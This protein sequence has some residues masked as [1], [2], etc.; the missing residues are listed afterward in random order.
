MSISE[1]E[2]K[3][4]TDT[5][6]D[7]S[8]PFPEIYDAI[9][10]QVLLLIFKS[11]QLSQNPEYKDWFEKQ[12]VVLNELCAQSNKIVQLLDSKSQRQSPSYWVQ[13]IIEPIQYALLFMRP[14][15][16]GFDSGVE[17]LKT[18]G[19]MKHPNVMKNKYP[20]LADK[21]LSEFIQDDFFSI[22][23]NNRPDNEAI[24]A[25]VRKGYSH[26]DLSIAYS[27]GDELIKK[28]SEY[29][30]I[31]VLEVLTETI[32]SFIK[33]YRHQNINLPSWLSLFDK[34]PQ[35][36][37]SGN[38]RDSYEFKKIIKLLNAGGRESFINEVISICGKNE[39]ERIYHRYA[40][41]YAKEIAQWISG[42]FIYLKY[43]NNIDYR[44][45]FTTISPELTHS[46][47][48]CEY[49]DSIAWDT[50]YCQ[51]S[52]SKDNLLDLIQNNALY[53]AT[54]ILADRLWHIY[55]ESATK[56]SNN[57]D[58]HLPVSDE[59]RKVHKSDDWK[60]GGKNSRR[61]Y[62]VIYSIE[63]FEDWYQNN[64]VL[65]INSKTKRIEKISVEERLAGLKCYDLK[66]GI[67]SKHKMKVKDGIYDEVRADSNLYSIS[68]M[69]DITLQRY[70]SKVKNIITKEI[71]L[72]LQ[73]QQN[74]NDKFPY[75][76]SSY[77]IK[78]LWG[79]CKY[80]KK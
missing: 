67:P 38:I 2:K 63:S 52:I 60:F 80:I 58:G 48:E 37:H 24:P 69:S 41:I 71:D 7:K 43:Q 68:S 53:D 15:Y 65:F 45:K 23:I 4:F 14:L 50:D 76:G 28:L 70:H 16:D 12:H 34:V 31:K 66:M 8:S 73:E 20:L 47:N 59:E 22:L 49:Q 13:E 5:L 25:S 44:W 42:I 61:E 39:V 74:K 27:Y 36:F 72:L 26:Q 21:R 9:S 75:S 6:L 40:S 32:Y 3:I 1:Y 46:L 33:D 56:R 51:I 18:W 77:A 19:D 35:G 30:N 10:E 62:E 64:N 29:G 57:K 79:K 78:P 54:N 11:R 55:Q 17:S